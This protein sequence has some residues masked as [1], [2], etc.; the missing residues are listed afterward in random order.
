[1]SSEVNIKNKQQRKRADNF[2][3]AEKMILTNLV[4]QYK[5]IIENKKSDAVTSKDKDKCWKTIEIAFNSRSSA[6]CRKKTPTLSVI[7]KT[8]T[9]LLFLPILIELTVCLI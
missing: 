3:E 6:K 7:K 9:L 8:P 2:S 5:D 4:L 1:M